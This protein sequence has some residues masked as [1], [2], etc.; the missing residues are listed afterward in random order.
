MSEENHRGIHWLDTLWLIFLLGYHMS[1]AS[2]V[3]FIALGGV[4]AEISQRV[5]E[6][7]FD[8]LDAP[9]TRVTGLD[10]PVP[11]GNLH[12]AV[13]PQAGPLAQTVL[14]MMGKTHSV[15]A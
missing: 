7:A 12:T 2:A 9:I 4:A 10:V 11:S 1:I 8:Y 6:E 14:K 3:G 5:M 13:V 15:V